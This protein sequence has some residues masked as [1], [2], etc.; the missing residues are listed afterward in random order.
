MHWQA[1][2]HQ[3]TKVVR[4]TAGAVYDVAIDLRP[5]SATYLRHVA[6]ELDSQNRRAIVI[7]G[8]VAHGFLTLMDE[9]EVEY[10]MDVPFASD[11]GRGARWNDPAFGIVW[12]AVPRVM[13]D[14]DRTYPD[15]V[16]GTPVP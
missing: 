9:T 1:A 2:P 7:P 16:V 14:R 13:S 10:M 15:F 11:F 12:P 5:S 8:G 4:C 6:V 3:E